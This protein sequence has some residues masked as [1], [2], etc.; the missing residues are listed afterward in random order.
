M[1]AQPAAELVTPVVLTFNEELNIERTLSSLRWARQAVV[2]DSGSSDATERIARSFPN[3][4][5]HTRQFDTHANQWRY[6]ID[7]ATARYVL[8]LDADYQVPPAFVDEL[9]TGFAPGNYVGGVAG[10]A[11]AIHGQEL[12]GSV[13]PA[14]LVVFRPDLVKISQPGHTQEMAIDGPV[15][16]FAAKLIHDDRKPLSRFVSSQMEYS[17]LEALRLGR[18]GTHRWQDRVRRLGLMPLIAG[19]G[20]YVKSGG[21]F[22]GSASLHYAYERALFECLLALRVLNPDEKAQ[23]DTDRK[24]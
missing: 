13:Y 22:K 23:N 17:R 8:A 7:L 15:Y 16:N 21:P 11:Y 19:V 20:A 2:V 4:C 18:N 9:S 12:A 14:K 1:N 24:R 3:V 10:F 6:A 5:W